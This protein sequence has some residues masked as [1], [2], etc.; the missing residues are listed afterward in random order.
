MVIFSAVKLKE[1][2]KKGRNNPL[3][4]TISRWC[5][6]YKDSSGAFKS[7]QPSL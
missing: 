7:Q 5:R 4:G 3:V 1:L 6:L 2:F